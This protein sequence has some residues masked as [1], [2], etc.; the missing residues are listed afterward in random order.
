MDALTRL[1]VRARQWRVSNTRRKQTPGD[2]RFSAAPG[3]DELNGGPG[4]DLKIRGGDGYHGHYGHFES[5]DH[6]G[7]SPYVKTSHVKRS[8]HRR[9]SSIKGHH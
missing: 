5:G 9:L 1:V 7:D 3:I 4:L 8:V 6:Y 2:L